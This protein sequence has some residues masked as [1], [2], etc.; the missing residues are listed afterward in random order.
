MA[1]IWL[2]LV[3]PYINRCSLNPDWRKPPPPPQ[4]KLL[5]RLGVM[6][7]KLSSPTQAL[8]TSRIS[9]AAGSPNV[10]LTIWQ[11][12]WTVNLILR[13]SFQLESGLSFPSRIQRAYRVYM[14]STLKLW[15]MLNFFS[16]DR[17]AKVIWPHS[18]LRKVL[19]PSS[20]H[21]WALLRVSSFHPSSS[22]MNMQ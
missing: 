14:V 10:F 7:T 2:S 11:G 16:P 13:L 18:V 8:T 19:H 9:S 21:F 22:A 4:Q 5:E 15:G 3:L 1:L 17:T 6:S 20:S 12:S